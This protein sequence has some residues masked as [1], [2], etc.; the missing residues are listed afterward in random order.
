MP[1]ADVYANMV[2][3]KCSLFLTKKYKDKDSGYVCDRQRGEIDR[4]TR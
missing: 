4:E 1:L 2:E 3:T